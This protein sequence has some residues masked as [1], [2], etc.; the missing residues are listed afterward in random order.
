MNRIQ[1]LK[2]L[3][4]VEQTQFDRLNYLDS[5]VPNSI[6]ILW[7]GDVE[8]YFRSELKVI[9]VSLNPSDKEFRK[10]KGDEYSTKVR[11]PAYNGSV[12]SI[13]NAYNNYFSTNPYSAWFKS[14]FDSVLGSFDASHYGNKINTAL[15]TDIGNSCATNPTWSKLNSS[16]KSVL[17]LLGSD[18]W[19]KL[20]GIVEPDIIL[21]SASEHFQKKIGFPQIGVWKEID[22]HAKRPLLLGKFRLNESKQTAVLFQ[23]QGRKPFLQTSKSEKLKFANHINS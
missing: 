16:D 3:I 18:L 23:V 19:H 6:P 7:F 15:H 1:S 9:T 14:S 13:Y 10:S 5:I 8:S 2:N 22:V 4:E 20:I 12:E 21:F 11:F 17:E